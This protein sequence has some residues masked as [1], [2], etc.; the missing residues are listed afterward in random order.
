MKQLRTK[1]L[2]LGFCLTSGL[3]LA[4]Q[5]FWSENFSANIPSSWTNTDASG[6]NVLWEW[7]ANNSSG[8]SPVYTG[9]QPFASATAAS[10]FVHVNSDGAGSLA[11][12]HVSQLTTSAINCAGRSKVFVKFQSHIG[13][14]LHTPAGS[15]RLRVSTNLNTWQEFVIFPDLLLGNSFS[16]NPE[17]S[18]LDIS[19][20]AANQST[21]YIQWQW[22]GNYEYMWNLDDIELFD[23]NPT[24]PH[25][26][27]ISNFFYPPSSFA[28]P[29]SQIA[30]DTFFFFVTLSNK[31]LQSMT[32]V[33]VKAT[34]EEAETHN[35]LFADSTTLNALAS[36][37]ADSLVILP[38][39]YA[40]ELPVG[41]YFVRYSVSADAPDERPSD[42]TGGSPFMV[43]NWVFAKE[44][45]AQ[46]ATRPLDE[47]P[48]YVGNYYVMSSGQF[49]QYKASKAEF[50]FATDP[51][52]LNVKDVKANLYFLK[53]KDNVPLNFAGFNLTQ[54]PGASVNWIGYADY[55]APDDMVNGKPQ[56]VNL[57]TLDDMAGIPLE[58]GGRYFLM[59]GYPTESQLTNHAFNTDIR[60]FAVVSTV[61]FS[62]Q[63]YLGGFGDDLSAVMRMQIDLVTTTDDKPLA[64]SAL[65]VFPNPVLDHVNLAV[66]F[67]QP[68][69]ATITI[70]D[71]NGRVL[72][73]EDRQGL[74]QEVLDYQ[75]PNLNPGT[76]LARIATQ[77]G[78]RTLQFVVQK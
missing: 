73:L 28:T 8:C 20:V 74:T 54:F 42:N 69:D 56:E 29:L 12:N 37:V 60:Y 15:T 64:E 58:P 76:Y 39:V 27:A 46:T 6:Q 30:T 24:P 10:G 22:I 67:D 70:A 33:K 51:N 17:V 40:P 63:W 65:Q 18:I 14:F 7:C 19:S 38:N 59:I 16:P 52:E 66:Q 62:D 35:V 4:Q 3:L 11:T 26:L 9:E 72:Q 2:A 55:E 57:F 75:L 78:T 44:N 53:V 34:V 1:L 23:E 77:K 45:Q 13:T 47:M 68:T 48:W 50:T 36:G 41:E 49:D 25:D 31:G 71:I 32:N 61:T 21:V 43:T 5:P